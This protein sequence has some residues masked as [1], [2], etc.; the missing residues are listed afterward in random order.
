MTTLDPHLIAEKPQP[1]KERS[2]DWIATSKQQ[3]AF[4]LL[5]DHITQELVYGGAAGGAKSFLGCSWLIINC[6]R[7]PGSRWLMGRAVLKQ[8]KQSTLLTFFDVCRK[9]KLKRGRDYNYNE[10]SGVITFSQSGS[11]I[12]L[13]DLYYYPSDPD[14]DSL[15]S[16]EYTGAFID[17]ASQIT[18]KAK[19][20]VRSRLRYKLDEY[21]IIPKVLM[22]C[23][24]TKNFLYTEFYKPWKEG[25]LPVGKGFIIAKVV[26]NP[27]LPE[28]YI[29]T[30]RTLDKTSQERLL[31]GNWE[32]DDDPAALMDFDA[33]TDLFTNPADRPDPKTLKDEYGRSL[34]D[35]RPRYIVCDVARFGE[36]R[37]VITVW[38][39]W[40]CVH[41][42]TY[43]KTSTT[44][45]AGLIK[46]KAK[47]HNVSAS[48]ILID[49]DG[50]GGGVLDQLYGAK[51]FIANTRAARGENYQN[52]KAQC[53]Y[54]LAA[55]VQ[56]R[57]IGVRIDDTEMKQ[58]LIAELEQIKAKDID[59]DGKL[60]IIPKDQ[61]KQALGRSPDLSD[62]LLMRMAFEFT[63]KPR[64]TFV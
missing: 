18:E 10:Q 12:Y 53:G 37:T 47:Q 20:V 21:G 38:Y 1:S 11:E 25:T 29:D 31:K 49:E 54:A 27:F 7:Y 44:T 35:P 33:I 34:P 41:V 8:L 58:S 30:L 36:D 22:T 28:S 42:Y 26:D 23:N 19:N 40:E 48:H 5:S 62:T 24:P 51:G 64:L 60:A 46:E 50:I 45:V 55:K 14:Y 61:V 15:G 59:K 6:F 57:E 63:A 17:E 43:K 13:K 16:T 2:I 3:L 56:A 39:G 9:F 32:Y 4:D 52:L